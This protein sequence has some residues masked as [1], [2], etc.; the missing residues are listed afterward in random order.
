MN[1]ELKAAGWIWALALIIPLCFALRDPNVD[2]SSFYW[3]PLVIASVLVVLTA[4]LSDPIRSGR[5]NLP[6]SLSAM[7]ITVVLLTVCIIVDASTRLNIAIVLVGLTISII[8]GFA[9]RNRYWQNC[10]LF[11]DFSRGR[12][13]R[14]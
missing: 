11:R 2:Y 3:P 6:A 7:G 14:T 12:W 13:R 8:M 5:F 4:V 10:M 1:W 9:D